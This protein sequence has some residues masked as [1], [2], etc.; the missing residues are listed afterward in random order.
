MVE[1]RD[2]DTA[3]AAKVSASGKLKVV[4]TA[5]T[6]EHAAT[7]VGDAYFVN[8]AT[9]AATLTTATG[10]TYNLIYLENS[11]STR[12]LVIEK[13]VISTDAA[14]IV[15]ELVKNTTLGAVS[16]NNAFTAVNANFSSGKAADGIFHTWNETGT[17]GIG[18]ITVGTI[19]ISNTLSTGPFL[20]PI[21][22]TFV[23][24]QGNNIVIRVTN[25]TG[26]NVEVSSAVR[27][28]YN[29]D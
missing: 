21:D 24:K 12:S 6:E 20:F 11:S 28:Y 27:F 1:I 15:V 29:G 16:A 26:A 3:R 22:G 13:I 23:L 2:A 25:A 10:N 19:L 17:V 8:T 7:D 9:T 18:G 14:D 4:S 5:H